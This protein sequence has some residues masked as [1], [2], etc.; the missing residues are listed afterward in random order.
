MTKIKELEKFNLFSEI[1]KINVLKIF[2]YIAPEDLDFYYLAMNGERFVS[3][4][5]LN[6]DFTKIANIISQMY[7]TKWDNLTD[8]IINSIPIINNYGSRTTEIA[9]NMGKENT[10]RETTNFVSGFNSEDFTDNT[11]DTEKSIL[12]YEDRQTVKE[13]THTNI[14]YNYLENIISYLQN[15]FIYDTMFTDINNI[16]T[17]SIYDIFSE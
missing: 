12:E 13:T 10:T 1:S 5:L 17:L 15:N 4:I 7:T 9:T 11:K 3:N 14:D 6:N 8:Y 2:S 16:I